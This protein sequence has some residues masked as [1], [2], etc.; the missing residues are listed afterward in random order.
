MFELEKNGETT[1]FGWAIV[2]F[3]GAFL[4]LGSVA[5]IGGGLFGIGALRAKYSVWSQG[6]VGQAELKR[7]DWNRQI[8]VRE[9][10]AKEESAVLLAQAEVERAKGVAKANQIIGKSL[11]GNEAYLRYL[12]INNLHEGKNQVIYVPTEA[13]LPILEATR[14]KR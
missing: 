10:K 5:I 6:K 3:I 13:N 4:L 12:W 14:G 1:L 7:A 2:I 8:M 9:A 11:Q